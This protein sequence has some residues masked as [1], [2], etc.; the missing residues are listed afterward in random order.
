MENNY[1]LSEIGLLP[2]FKTLIVII[3]VDTKFSTTLALLSAK[4]QSHYDILLIDC[5][6]NELEL[7]F[8]EKLQERYK[9]Y[10]IKLPL[11]IHGETLDFVFKNVNAEYILLLDSDAEIINFSFFENEL[12]F[13]KDTFGVGFIHGP[14]RMDQGDM[15]GGKF[16][17]Y[18]E[19]MYIP[20]VLLKTSIIIE[21]I[22]NGYSFAAKKIYND[23]PF[24]PFISHLLYFRFYF[25]FFQKHDIPFLKYFR[26]RYNDF[27]RPSMVYYDTGAEI[28]MFLKYKLGYNFIGLPV[29][30][31]DRYFNHYHGITRKVMNNADDNSSDYKIVINEIV[32]KLVKKYQFDRELFL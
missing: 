11:K 23:F 10:L 31:H 19:R 18:Q 1:F 30:F 16:S 32:D 28:F 24:I 3:N 20:C 14:N 13:E 7:K 6:K 9:F 5:S 26:R 4:R 29:K 25:K 17:Y 15:K 27:Y 2:A 8:F 12:L 21:A 22:N